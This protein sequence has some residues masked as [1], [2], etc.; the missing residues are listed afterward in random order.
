MR[1]IRTAIFILCISLSVFSNSKVFSDEISPETPVDMVVVPE[2]DFIMGSNA[3]DSSRRPQRRVYL[4]GF[5][6]DKHETTVAAYKACVDAGV[7]T[8]PSTIGF[9]GGENIKYN[10]WGKSER[11][12]HP[13]N[14]VDWYQAK[15]FCEWTGKRLPTEAEWEKAA[16][17]TD[18][19][20]YP[21]GKQRPNCNHAVMYDDRKGNGCGKNQTWPVG[22]R[23]HGASPYGALDMVGNVWEWTADWYDRHYYAD[24]PNRNPRGPSLGSKRVVRGGGFSNLANFEAFHRSLDPPTSAIVSSGF[25]CARSI[26]EKPEQEGFDTTAQNISTDFWVNK[27]SE[28]VRYMAMWIT[29]VTS[30]TQ[31]RNVT[32]LKKLPVLRYVHVS[33]API[34]DLSPIQRGTMV[35]ITGTPKPSP[36]P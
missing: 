22:S 33:D 20:T 25:R 23:N 3:G 24:A 18:G 7:C 28:M 26:P 8:I 29:Q 30:Y 15:T 17:G 34:E 27:F 35:R 11:S 32:P 6:I 21:W 10:N 16:R 9:C 36:K 19:R 13:V 4:D 1:E 31:V 14:C 12:Q 5:F 2:G